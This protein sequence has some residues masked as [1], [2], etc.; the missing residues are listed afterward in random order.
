MPNIFQSRT[1]I[2]TQMWIRPVFLALAAISSTTLSRAR[3]IEGPTYS[4]SS[5]S[6]RTNSNA[7][8]VCYEN[9]DYSGDEVRLR[10]YAPYLNLYNF[11]NR[12]RS[13]CI[14]GM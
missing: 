11:N 7:Y 1:D 13:C 3:G 14:H 8:L 5:S 6:D 2:F 12:A 4:S 10:E 9:S